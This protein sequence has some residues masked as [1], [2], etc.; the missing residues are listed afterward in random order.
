MPLT[1]L[2]LGPHAAHF[3]TTM[4]RWPLRRGLCCVSN[5]GNEV[6]G[7]LTCLFS[8]SWPGCVSK[9]SQWTSMT[10]PAHC[11]QHLQDLLRG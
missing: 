4:V 7:K 8:L 11:L 9:D 3:R 6:L 5:K 10:V 2:Q 1:E